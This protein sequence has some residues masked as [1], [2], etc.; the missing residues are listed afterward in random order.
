MEAVKVIGLDIAKSALQVHGIDAEGKV[1]IC[2]QVKRRYVLS[3]FR[4]PCLVVE[5]SARDKMRP[6]CAS[7]RSHRRRRSIVLRGW[8]K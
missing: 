8:H 5:L 6:Q 1:I 7:Q 4:K 2:R 3:F